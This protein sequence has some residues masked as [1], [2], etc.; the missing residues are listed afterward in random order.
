MYTYYII[1]AFNSVQHIS[2]THAHTLARRYIRIHPNALLFSQ[3]A[4]VQMVQFGYLTH[5]TVAGRRQR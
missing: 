3:F 4:M 5:D 2:H 1:R